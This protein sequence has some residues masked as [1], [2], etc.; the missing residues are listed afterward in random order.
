[1]RPIRA[2]ERSGMRPMRCASSAGK[3]KKRACCSARSSFSLMTL[4]DE[5]FLI[6][7]KAAAAGGRRAVRIG[8]GH[9]GIAGNHGEGLETVL[10]I[11]TLHGL[12]G[13]IADV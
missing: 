13:G 4:V 6:V 10:A 12:G 8:G 7:A 5:E 2:R 3:S 1:M 9:R 11:R